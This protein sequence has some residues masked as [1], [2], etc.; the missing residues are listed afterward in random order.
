ML[1]STNAF[2][3][4]ISTNL[5]NTGVDGD[6]A[7]TLAYED[8]AATFTGQVTLSGLD[9]ISNPY[10][11]KLEQD[12]TQQGGQLL[13]QVGRTWDNTIW[14]STGDVHLANVGD[15]MTY[16]EIQALA[17]SGHSLVG[18]LM[19]SYFTI[20]GDILTLTEDNSGAVTLITRG[21][22]GSFVIPFS[23]DFSWHVA[24]NPQMGSIVM[25]YGAYDSR[26]LITRESDWQNPLL[27]DN[28]EFEVGAAPVPEPA[29]LLLLGSGLLGLAGFRKKIIR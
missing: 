26:F 28:I 24:G 27:Q 25:P 7:G 1:A 4:L 20:S 19:F 9:A 3:A 17:T 10:Q 23:A 22:D 5:I 6:A 8:F 29:T 16:A 18:Y 2:T 13:S 14:A 12:W 21:S 11:L 15:Y